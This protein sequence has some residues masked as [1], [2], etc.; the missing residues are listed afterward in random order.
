MHII[1]VIANFTDSP[2]GPLTGMPCYVNKIANCLK[3]R[4]HHIE[5]VAGANDDRK[6]E[7]KG[8]TINNVQTLYRINNTIIEDLIAIVQRE[9]A[10]QRKLHIINEEEIIDIVQYAG[11][12]GTGMLHS[13]KCPS[14]LRLSTYS[15]VQYKDNEVFKEHIK[16]YSFFER[17]AGIRATGVISPGE[18]IG[19]SFSKDIKKEVTIIETPYI[20]EYE[21][22]NSAYNS[23]SKKRYFLFYGRASRDKGFEVLIKA[24]PKILE[25]FNDIEFVFA[26]WDVINE[27]GSAVK[28]LRNNILE[29]DRN[30]FIYLGPLSHNLLIP[31]I[32]NAEFVVLPSIVDNLPNSCIE[33]MFMDKIVIGT[34][35]SSIE[36]MIKN[37]ENGLL[38]KPGDVKDLI[39][40]V[41]IVMNLSENKKKKYLKRIK[42]LR[43]PYS[44]N[45]AVEK[46][47]DYYK[48]I[49]KGNTFNVRYK[50]NV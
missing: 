50:N 6:W 13:L 35:G 19:Q 44:E 14:V 7:Y 37:E 11:W 32:K 33:A 45:V 38:S 46:L 48:T 43:Q 10:F 4:G 3:K 1:L 8:I 40:C 16:I 41:E 47:E 29:K 25:L 30:R 26:G 9:Y 23:L 17:I 42:E 22:D 28:R 18:K 21:F 34:Y 24:I 36:Q 12:S 20:Q 39:K 5:I 15:K 49:I 31:I 27:K 2:Y